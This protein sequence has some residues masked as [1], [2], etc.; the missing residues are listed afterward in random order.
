MTLIELVAALTIAI[1]P[2]QHVAEG[3]GWRADWRCVGGFGCTVELREL[4]RPIPEATR[5]PLTVRAIIAHFFPE[6][7]DF[8]Y[9]VA[10]C[11]TGGTFNPAAVGALG[12]RGIFQ[13]RPEYHGPVP[14]DVWGQVAQARRI[15]LAQGWRPWSCA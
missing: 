2:T 4:P 15:Y 11:E 9:G 8:A 10:H 3:D 5:P 6:Q 12:E 7:P 1:A 13:V 14:S